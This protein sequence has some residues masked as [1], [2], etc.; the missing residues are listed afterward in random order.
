MKVKMDFRNE[1]GT[2]LRGSL[3]RSEE[4]GYNV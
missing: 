3:K 4:V 1:A 2:V